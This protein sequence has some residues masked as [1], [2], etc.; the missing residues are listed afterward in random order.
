MKH[1]DTSTQVHRLGRVSVAWNWLTARL[2]QRAFASFIHTGNLRVTTAGGGVFTVGDGNGKP[3]AISSAAA[4]LGV[5]LDPDLRFG[6]RHCHVNR[7]FA[8]QMTMAATV[9]AATVAWRHV[10]IA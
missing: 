8:G 5:L 3:L 9:H 10:S 6:E 1:S 7:K 4:Q 2:L